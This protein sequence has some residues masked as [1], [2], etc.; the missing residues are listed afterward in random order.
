MT[1][2]SP[3]NIAGLQ[4]LADL[5]EHKSPVTALIGL[6]DRGWSME[7]IAREFEVSYHAVRYCAEKH[8]IRFKMR[9]ARPIPV[10]RRAVDATRH[11]TIKEAARAL[12]VGKTTVSKWRK[13]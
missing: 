11:L 10:D 6:R 12:G 3:S 1:Y 13:G 7:G 5:L 4:S 8:D 2:R 9:G